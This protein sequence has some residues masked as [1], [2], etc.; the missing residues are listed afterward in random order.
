MTLAQRM[1]VMNAGRAE[2]IGTP[3]EV[4][5]NPATLFVAGFIGSPAMNFMPAKAEG[6]SRFSLLAGGT[7]TAAIGGSEAGRSVTIGV[8]PEHFRLSDGGPA[9]VSGAVEMV[10][11]LGADTLL[12]V[13]HGNATIIARIPHGVHPEIGSTMHFAAEPSNVFLFDSETGARI[14]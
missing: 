13:G 8:R 7:A 10:E 9:T 4:Y 5:Q 6:G 2:Q 3:M 12:H 1:I 14:K 11:E